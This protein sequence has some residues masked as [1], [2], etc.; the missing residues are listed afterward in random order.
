MKRGRPS[1]RS[2]EASRGEP[3]RNGNL[4]G[5]SDHANEFEADPEFAIPD[6]VLPDETLDLVPEHEDELE[7]LPEEG[8]AESHIDDPIRMYLMQMG[9]I[10]MLC[11][12]DEIS[13]A[14]DIEQTR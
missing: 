12:A 14:R 13:S 4:N 2:G 6:D 1:Q 11:R 10:P 3:T 9:E 5:A 8:S 7:H